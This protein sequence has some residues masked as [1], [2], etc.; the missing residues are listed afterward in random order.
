MEYY[1]FSQYLKERFGTKVYKVALHAGLTCPNR[2]GTLG[3]GGC[4]FCSADGSG[5]FAEQAAFSVSCQIQKAKERVKHKNPNGV[6]IAYFQ[7]FTNTY[8]PIDYLERIF[9]E[10][11]EEEDV[12]AI[13]IA[14]RPDCLSDDV[15]ALLK[16][17]NKRKP[18]WVELGLQT[19]HE[20]SAVYIRRG[21]ETPVF[22]E[23]VKKL[24]AIGI[25]Q[26][27]VHVILGL[28]GEDKSMMLQTV[29]YVGHSGAS[30]IKL[31]LLHVLKHT[32]LAKEYQAGKFEVLTQDE[33]ITLV[34]E[35]IAILPEH[36][37]IHRM[38]GDGSRKNLI[39]P[40]WS[41]DKKK[42]LNQLH[43]AISNADRAALRKKFAQGTA[44]A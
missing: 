33:Y 11:M 36:M 24:R 7:A 10:A 15:L 25:E 41:T 13:S 35:C 44:D 26:I 43:Q 39:A 20:K 21:Y 14:T 16:R 31:Q 1:G 28:P 4:I 23:A 19:I 29:D 8:G 22:D 6:Y 5:D 2:D 37:V 3:T 40:M 30:G 9:S 38:T 42:V 27:I 32:D 17:L 34:T 12:V 18:V